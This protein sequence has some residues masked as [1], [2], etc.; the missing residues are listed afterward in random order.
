MSRLYHSVV[1]IFRDLTSGSYVSRFLLFCF[2]FFMFS[3]RN[4]VISFPQDWTSYK[5]NKFDAQLIKT[6]EM[7]ASFYV[8]ILT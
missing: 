7:K 4:I 8:K 1:I 6:L 5:H 2:S 3:W